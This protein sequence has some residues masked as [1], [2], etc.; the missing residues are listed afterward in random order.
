MQLLPKSRTLIAGLATLAALLGCTAW[1]TTST[2]GLQTLSALASGASGGQL[3]IEQASGR[4]LGPLTLGQVRWSSPTLQVDIDGLQLAWSPGELLHGQLQIGELSIQR[5]HIESAASDTPP[6]RPTDLSLPLPI[7]LE[8]MVI[9]RLEYGNLLQVRDLAG[10]LHSDGSKHALDDFHATF[11]DASLSGRARLDGTVPFALEAD[12]AIAGQ[13]EKHALALKLQASGPLEKIALAAVAE[14]GISGR[15]DLVLTPFAKAPF[16]SAQIALDEF[17]PAAW[18]AAGPSA[19]LALRADLQPQG[20]GIA[21]DFSLANRIPGPLD[22]QRL[23][24]ARLTGRLAWQDEIARLDALHA[25][26]PG[27][28]ELAGSG[29]WQNGALQLDWQASRLDAAQ[30]VAALRATQLNGPISAKLDANRQSLQVDL[31]DTRFALRAEASQAAGEIDLASLE[32]SSGPARLKAHGKLALGKDMAFSGDGELEH[33]DPS[34]FA[35]LAPA[36]INARFAASGKLQPQAQ[37]DAEFALRESLWAGQPLAGQG[38]LKIA[39]PQ[40]PQAEIRLQAGVN[41]LEAHG[42]FGR[43]GDR[44]Q[45]ELD[46]PQL[47]PYGIEGGASGHLDIA[48][49]P[50]QLQLAAR[51]QAARLGLPGRFRISGLQLDAAAGGAANAPLKLDLAAATLETPDRPGLLRLLRIQLNGNRQAHR[52]SASADL[53]GKNHLLLELSGGLPASGGLDWRGQLEQLSMLAVDPARNVRLVAPAPLQLAGERWHLGPARLAGEPLDW[54]ATLDVG[55]DAKQ[56]AASLQARGSRVGR[57][58]AQLNAGMQGAG[59]L[60]R[61]AAWQGKLNSEI[62]DLAWL[63]ELIGEQW[64]TAGRFNGEL[65]LAGTPDKPVASGRFR[66]SEL[67]LRLPEQGLNLNRG[68]LAVDLDNNLLRVGKLG[69]DSVLQAAPRPLQLSGRGDLAA[70]TGKPGRLEITGEMQVDRPAGSEHAFLDVHLDRLGAWQLPDQ[71]VSVSGSGRLSWQDGTLG[72]KGKLAV[73]AGYWQLAAS[74]APR[75]S[76]DVVV[77]RPGQ[78]KANTS[79]RPK[80]DLDISTELGDNFL[81]SGAGLNT[82]LTGDIRLRAS[83][84]DLPRAS[85]TIRT[86]AG[87]FE[88]YGQQ[89]AI[90][91]GILTFQGLPDNPALDVRAVRQGLSVEPGVHISGTAQ[92]PVIKLI[93]D[94]ELP[95]SEKLAW[96]ILGHGPEQMGAGDATVLLSAAGGLLGNDAGNVVQQLKKSFGFDELGVRS[97]Q[98]GDNGSRQQISRVAAGTVDNTASTGAQIFSVGKRLSSN[99]MLSY[100][101]ALGK[102]ESVVKLSISLS[103]QISVIGRAGSDNAVDLFYTLTFGREENKATQPAKPPARD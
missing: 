72:A 46:A 81:F 50:Q 24:L 2:S 28:G 41:R 65:K 74:G 44:L 58:D 29:R 22:R 39:W 25:T 40:V 42:A 78:D 20:S 86:R 45:V 69:F 3:H 56:L 6:T 10:R 13:L 31:K 66:G 85:G 59:A 37:V 30:L 71:W 80:L 99:A 5:L 88:A 83:G 11:G 27:G 103:R 9:S 87:R 82:R 26:L 97:G 95:D 36:R 63:G 14:S 7:D 32:L 93:S 51:L 54:Q 94:P 38:R 19:R 17:D 21:G 64:R 1:L 100:E 91:R 49:T 8:K 98:I 84:R 33:F 89:L 62:A 92:R 35:Q 102:A 47:G 70:L 77:R 4:L 53:A 73:D 23:P 79:L 48:G 76:D 18:Q 12:A 57:I 43:P 68:E 75:L 61:Q 52:L 34:R 60:N 55:A 15:A 16:A 90:E 67:A 96:L 101:Q